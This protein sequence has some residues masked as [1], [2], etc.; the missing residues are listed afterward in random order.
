MHIYWLKQYELLPKSLFQ[1]FVI[2]II[3]LKKAIRVHINL[4]C[5][6]NVEDAINTEG[7]SWAS[8]RDQRKE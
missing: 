8:S 1:D 4:G 7:S 5:L 2:T 3:K 6:Y